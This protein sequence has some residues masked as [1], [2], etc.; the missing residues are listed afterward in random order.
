MSLPLDIDQRAG[1]PD[2]LCALLREHPR[3]SWQQ[4]MTPLARFWIDKHDDFRRQC[5]T[6]QTAVDS[7][8][9]RPDDFEDFANEVVPRTRLLLSLL[10]GHHHVEDFHY[11][12]AFRA[13]DQRL[14]PG[15]DVL[16]SDHELLHENS[17][18]VVETMHVMRSV[19]HGV[20]AGDERRRAADRY[21]EKS[22]LLCRRIVRHLD[23]EEDLVI[24]LMLTHGS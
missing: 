1:W 2:E 22:G 10:H 15:F 24:P 14:G 18:S 17:M 5:S 6:L 8:R 19:L 20:G 3:A 7:F 11:F 16:A 9:E 4:N 21:I 23:D 13:A 12:P